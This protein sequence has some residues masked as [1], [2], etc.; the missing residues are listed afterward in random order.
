MQGGHSRKIPTWDGQPKQ[1]RRYVKQLC[2]YVQGTKPQDRPYLATLFCAEL[3]GSARLLAM[4]WRDRVSE[5]KD[6]V[7]V[8][9]RMMAKSPLERRSMRNAN[10]T[11]NQYFSFTR[12]QGETIASFLIREILAYEEFLEA[13]MTLKEQK[14]G[15]SADTK[16]FGLPIQ[17]YPDDSASDNRWNQWCYRHQCQQW[18][19]QQAEADLDESDEAYQERVRVH[20]ESG[21]GQNLCSACGCIRDR[22]AQASSSDAVRADSWYALDS[23]ILETLRGWKLVTSACLHPD[24]HRHVLCSTQNRMEYH[25]VADSLMTLYDEDENFGTRYLHGYE[26][27][28]TE[29]EWWAEEAGCED[30]APSSEDPWQDWS[31]PTSN[32]HEPPDSSDTEAPREE[33]GLNEWQQAEPR[34]H[35]EVSRTL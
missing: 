27:N 6:G 17:V 16:T 10:A 9:I 32:Y 35:R 4:S 30:Q 23:F 28:M 1:W 8:F 7:L 12:F 19:D 22:Q 26:V 11:F 34:V 29:D 5:G 24:E 2:W 33:T 15:V 3:T 21:T 25:I 14:D 20:E 13:I 18:E 31:C